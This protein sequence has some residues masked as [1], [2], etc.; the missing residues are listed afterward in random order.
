MEPKKLKLKKAEQAVKHNMKQLEL[1]RKA[2]QEITEK[3]QSL[4]DQFSQMNQK[5]A[6][7]QSQIT[8]C[9]VKVNRAFKLVT[10]LVN[11]RMRWDSNIKA[12]Q[13][14]NETYRHNVLIGATI[15][16][17]LSNVDSNFRKLA[18]S[19]VLRNSGYEKDDFSMR[20]L[21]DHTSI[22]ASE[23]KEKVVETYVIIDFSRKIPFIIDPHGESRKMLPRLLNE[24]M[25]VLD[26]VKRD[27]LVE[28]CGAVQTGKTLILDNVTEPLPLFVMQ[29]LKPKL[30]NGNSSDEK[31]N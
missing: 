18:V 8:A 16:A 24:K 30:I 4:S 2:L 21:L 26:M 14:E 25:V 1:R 19:Q 15:I 7:L 20:S 28:V 12:L 23:K 22:L 5:K 27:I 3:L 11:E 6:D 10:A 31:V 13:K 29:L 9:E 17:Y